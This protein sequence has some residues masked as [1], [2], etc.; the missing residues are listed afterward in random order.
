MPST[1]LPARPSRSR[2]SILLEHFGPEHTGV[3]AA[4][5]QGLVAE[6]VLAQQQG[7]AAAQFGHLGG[8]PVA[9]SRSQSTLELPPDTRLDR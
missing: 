4:A 1:S 2:L 5:R 3:G 8:Q 9:R 6:G 7:L